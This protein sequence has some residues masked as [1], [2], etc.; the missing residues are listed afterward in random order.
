MDNARGEMDT[1][2]GVEH[3]MQTG[4]AAISGAAALPQESQEGLVKQLT[5]KCEGLEQ[6]LASEREAAHQAQTD[7]ASARREA[8]DARKELSLALSKYR[9]ALLASAPE[10]PPELVQGATVSELDGSFAGA[11]ALMDRLRRSD[12]SVLSPRQKIL[13]GLQQ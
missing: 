2:L 5:A 7:A 6:Q 8:E 9:S 11:Q 10:V 1:Q 4:D 12:T 13:L 3:E